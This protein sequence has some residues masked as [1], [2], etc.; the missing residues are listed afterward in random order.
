MSD[1]LLRNNQGEASYAGRIIPWHKAGTVNVDGWKTARE[2][3]IAAHIHD[4]EIVKVPVFV[5]INGEDIRFPDRQALV[6][7][8]HRLNPEYGFLDIVSSD[9]GLIQNRSIAQAVDDSGLPNIWPV[10]TVGGIYDGAGMFISLDAGVTRLFPKH[11]SED[12]HAYFLVSECRQRGMALSIAITSVQAVC[13]N[14]VRLALETSAFTASLRHSSTAEAELGFRIDVVGKLRMALE[15][16]NEAIRKLQATVVSSEQAQ[17]IIA[18][19]YPQP[20]QPQKSKMAE[21]IRRLDTT[22]KV[23][24]QFMLT[25]DDTTKAWEAQRRAVA[26]RREGAFALFTLISDQRPV[27]AGNAYGV[28]SAIADI[29]DYRSGGGKEESSMF[30][31]RAQAKVRASKAAL[32]LV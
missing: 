17:Q 31:K 27:L 19:A 28:I 32:A 20:V 24:E 25:L 14:T 29:E 7:L 21:E 4:L 18:A 9:F 2:A 15:E 30:G 26:E 13:Q 11:P 22:G 10:D 12:L 3:V 23:A 6:R 8:P 1:G 5:K 16:G